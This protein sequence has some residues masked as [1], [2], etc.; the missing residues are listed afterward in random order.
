MGRYSGRAIR[1]AIL[2]TPVFV[3]VAVFF[4]VIFGIALASLGNGERLREE[5]SDSS[6]PLRLRGSVIGVSSPSQHAIDEIILHLA[7]GSGGELVDLT[8]GNTFI[9]YID[10]DNAITFAREDFV[11]LGL[12]EANSDGVVEPGELYEIKIVDLMSKLDP[13]LTPNKQFT[14]QVNLPV[15]A[16]FRFEGVTPSLFAPINVLG[17]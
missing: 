12:G 16:T 4:A 2:A 14:I 10:A 17:G 13:D 7:H 5:F 8:S 9:S 6:S 15:G 3:T 11:V 1:L